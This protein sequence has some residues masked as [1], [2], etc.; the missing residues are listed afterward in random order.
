MR[1]RTERND[2]YKDVTVQE[3]L[4]TYEGF[5]AALGEGYFEGAVLDRIDNHKGYSIDNCQWLTKAQHAVKTNTEIN[6]R[7]TLSDV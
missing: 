1:M 5:K 6:E 7:R 2:K 4:L 3:T